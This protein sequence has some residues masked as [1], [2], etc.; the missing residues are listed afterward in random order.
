MLLPFV[1][2][3][4]WFDSYMWCGVKMLIIYVPAGQICAETGALRPNQEG[5][6]SVK[7]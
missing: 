3:S 6:P 4:L 2:E 7:D 1:K 5:I